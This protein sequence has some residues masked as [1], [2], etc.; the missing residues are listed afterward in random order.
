MNYISIISYIV[1]IAVLFLNMFY[2]DLPKAEYYLVNS[3]ALFVIVL[4]SF[5][6]QKKEMI[7]NLNYKI[8]KTIV[9]L[10]LLS[11]LVELI[12]TFLMKPFQARDTLIAA[13]SLIN[14]L[15]FFYFIFKFEFKRF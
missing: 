7:R 6:K 11:V 14:L 12:A 8:F 4:V 9:I 2:F 13:F 15:I 1:L 10:S 3:V 5:L